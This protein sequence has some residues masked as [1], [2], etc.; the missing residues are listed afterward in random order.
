MGGQVLRPFPEKA[1]TVALLAIQSVHFLQV[2]RR[3]N[4]PNL[5]FP[6]QEGRNGNRSEVAISV[7]QVNPFEPLLQ[8]QESMNA[9]QHIRI[10]N[11]TTNSPPST[12]SSK[13]DIPGAPGRNWIRDRMTGTGKRRLPITL[14]Y[15]SE[16]AAESH[17]NAL[18]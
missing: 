13:P 1:V 6:G 3:W 18:R 4:H 17:I 9:P 2:W 12:V 7:L 5:G 11:A 8:S 16:A 10:G 15:H 14:P